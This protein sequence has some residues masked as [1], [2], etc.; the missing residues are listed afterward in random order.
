MDLKKLKELRQERGPDPTHMAEKLG[1][2]GKSG[3]CQLEKGIVKMTLATAK[4][5]ADIFGLEIKEIFLVKKFKLVE[6][7][8]V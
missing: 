8:L 5:I 7:N 2:K 1:Y 3:Y 6:Q 4:E